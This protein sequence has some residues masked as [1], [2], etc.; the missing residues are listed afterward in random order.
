MLVTQAGQGS[1]YLVLALYVTLR[2]DMSNPQ[3]HSAWLDASVANSQ[4][5][6]LQQYQYN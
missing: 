3:S 5:E 6:P 2:H 4:S 1:R